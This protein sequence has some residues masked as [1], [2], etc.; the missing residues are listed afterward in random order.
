[1]ILA[2][3]NHS[4][5]DLCIKTTTNSNGNDYICNR[6]WMHQSRKHLS[7]QNAK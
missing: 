3:Q 7:L 1:V 4:K 5:K 2:D 6:T